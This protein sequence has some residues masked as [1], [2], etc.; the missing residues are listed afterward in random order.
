MLCG[1][2][3]CFT[4]SWSGVYVWVLVSRFWFGHVRCPWTALP[5]TALPGTALPWTAQ[6]FALF[7]S[8]SFFLLSLVVPSV[9]F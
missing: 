5:V 2:G 7:F 3:S 1:V 6:N 9:E 8:L 4:V